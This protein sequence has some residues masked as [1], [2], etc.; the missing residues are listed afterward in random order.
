MNNKNF[1][2]GSQKQ[3]ICSWEKIPAYEIRI[4]F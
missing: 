4:Q 3:F 1:S 2:K